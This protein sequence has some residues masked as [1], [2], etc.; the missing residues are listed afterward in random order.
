V[1]WMLS[2]YTLIVILRHRE[3]ARG[4][5]SVGADRAA[6]HHAVFITIMTVAAPPFSR[7]NPVPPTA[8]A[9]TRCSKTTGMITHPIALYLGFTGFPLPSPSPWPALVTVV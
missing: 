5:L 3:R 6:R 8:A 4:A 1:G 2:L 9:S 7:L